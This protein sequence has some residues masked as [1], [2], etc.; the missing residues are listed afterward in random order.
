MEILEIQKQLIENKRDEYIIKFKDLMTD[1]IKLI[2][3]PEYALI[4]GGYILLIQLGKNINPYMRLAELVVK[5]SNIDSYHYFKSKIV[6]NYIRKEYDSE[7][8]R[9]NVEEFIRFQFCNFEPDKYM[10][11]SN[12]IWKEVFSDTN[13][14]YEDQFFLLPQIWEYTHKHFIDDDTKLP[15]LLAFSE[16]NYDRYRTIYDLLQQFFTKTITKE[17]IMEYYAE[18]EKIE[19]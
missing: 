1:T 2:L 3:L 19:A 4:T 12:R 9:K 6:E 13:F 18:L 5:D 16:V 11:Y 14:N 7:Q 15:G 17:A 10:G 8:T